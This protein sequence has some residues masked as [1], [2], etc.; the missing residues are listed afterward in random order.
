MFWEVS[1]RSKSSQ[2]KVNRGLQLTADKTQLSW[3][4]FNVLVSKVGRNDFQLMEFHE[5]A[6]VEGGLP[7]RIL[8]ANAN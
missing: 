8:G 6:V 4:S 2:K 1:G 3:F 7:R 5:R